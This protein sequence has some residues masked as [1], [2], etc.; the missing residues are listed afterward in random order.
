ME[1]VRGV[2]ITDYCD[3]NR[4]TSRDRL[5]LFIDVC[6]AVQHAHHKGIVHRDLKPSNIPVS[7]HD[8]TP[9]I[10]RQ[11]QETQ[12]ALAA[13]A[14]ARAELEDALK[15]ERRRLH[16][17]RIARADLEW[18]ACNVGRAECPT[19]SCH[20]ERHYLKRLC[21]AELRAFHGHAQAIRGV[22][23]RPEGRRLASASDD[24]TVK[25][26]SLDASE[27]P[28]TLAGHQELVA[29]VAFCPDGR[30]L[31]SASGDWASGKPGEV[32]ICR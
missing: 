6:H 21:H 7:S 3:Q 24:R 10:G 15:R 5:Q 1:L 29:A 9:V 27:P 13:E 8:G 32:K 18:W 17:Q 28:V 31:A 23:F 11:Q 4:L 22:A 16:F 12:E 19:E 25:V 30:R 2:P 14:L 26:W 20:W